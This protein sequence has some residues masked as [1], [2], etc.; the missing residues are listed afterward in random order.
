VEIWRVD[1]ARQLTFWDTKE[2]WDILNRNLALNCGQAANLRFQVTLNMV[3][4][5]KYLNIYD[6]ADTGKDILPFPVSGKIADYEFFCI[7][8]NCR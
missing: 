1:D 6:Y 4:L 8:L 3:L 5:L 7:T 2:I